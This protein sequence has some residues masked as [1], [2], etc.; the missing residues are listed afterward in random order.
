MARAIVIGVDG[1]DD[2]VAVA[3][4]AGSLA[5]RLGLRSVLA[6]VVED[7]AGFRHGMATEHERRAQ[8]RRTT[9]MLA[10]RHRAASQA[11]HVVRFG[12]PADALVRLAAD[13]DAA[14]IAVGS[15]GR[16]PLKS[17]LMGSVSLALA[18]RSGFPVLVVPPGGR[19]APAGPR[20]A[21]LWSFGR[22]RGSSARV[23][24]LRRAGG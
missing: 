22:S 13:L 12:E 8:E 18:T 19:R 2:A 23:R 17:A 4:Q 9:E 3:T 7:Q 15:R 24:R 6:H 21:R 20:R 11:E 14:L 10:S 5:E 16:G 1:S